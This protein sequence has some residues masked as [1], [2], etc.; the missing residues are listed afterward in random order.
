MSRTAA[1]SVGFVYKAVIGKLPGNLLDRAA[2]KFL[3]SSALFE[4][5]ASG[6][7]GREPLV[8]RSRVISAEGTLRN[9]DC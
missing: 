9:E 1:V 5:T 4:F 7:I 6:M 8:E 3:L 2:E